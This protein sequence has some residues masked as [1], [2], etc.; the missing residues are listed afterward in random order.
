VLFVMAGGFIVASRETLQTSYGLKEIAP[1]VVVAGVAA[2][3]S[4]LVAGKAI[5]AVNALTAAI[6]GQATRRP[7]PRRAGHRPP[8]QLRSGSRTSRRHPRQHPP[9][10]RGRLRRSSATPGLRPRPYVALARFRR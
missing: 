1:R 5:E 4:L 9:P 2:N 8:R 7:R 10:A 3:V 6:A